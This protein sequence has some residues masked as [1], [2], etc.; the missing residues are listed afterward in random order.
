MKVLVIYDS[1]FGNTK[2]VAEAMCVAPGPRGDGELD[3][4]VGA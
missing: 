2:R 3:R 4:T 1:V